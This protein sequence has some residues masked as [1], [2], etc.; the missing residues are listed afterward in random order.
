M[1]MKTK[2][3]CSTSTKNENANDGVELRKGKKSRWLS[4]FVCVCMNIPLLW[5]DVRATLR[6]L[7]C[8]EKISVRKL[9]AAEYAMYYVCVCMCLYRHQPSAIDDA[10]THMC[11]H[12]R[13]AHWPLCAYIFEHIST[14][15]VWSCCRWCWL[16][17]ILYMFIRANTWYMA[18]R[19][20]FTVDCVVKD[21]NFRL[22]VSCICNGCGCSRRHSLNV[23]EYT[24]KK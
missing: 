3:A 20:T 1:K 4:V 7:L 12:R 10:A 23:I 2:I 8:T 21:I 11:G 5:V 19:T 13:N 6:C 16:I 18:Q 22:K 17:I 15:F 14:R 24:H 9:V